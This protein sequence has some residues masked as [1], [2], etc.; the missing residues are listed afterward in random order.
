[1]LY[2]KWYVSDNLKYL[3][4]WR[5][6]PSGRL[7]FRWLYATSNEKRQFIFI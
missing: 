4:A 2:G 6:C 3:I 1:M 7:H 5:D